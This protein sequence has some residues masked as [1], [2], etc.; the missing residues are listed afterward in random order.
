[1]GH[2][3]S[4]EWSIEVEAKPVLLAYAPNICGIVKR[5]MKVVELFD[6]VRAARASR[7]SYGYR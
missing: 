4:T 7:R 5:R 2:D 3:A 1:V 6:Q